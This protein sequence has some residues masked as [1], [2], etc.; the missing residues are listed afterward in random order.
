MLQPPLPSERMLVL[1][2]CFLLMLHRVHCGRGGTSV[3]SYY[4]ELR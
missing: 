4:I 2:V 3:V 1:G